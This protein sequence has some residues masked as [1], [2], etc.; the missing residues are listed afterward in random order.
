MNT[1]ATNDRIDW[2][3]TPVDPDL[4]RQLS[5]PNDRQGFIQ[6]AGHLAILLLLGVITYFV[7]WHFAWYWVIPCLLAY[8]SAYNMLGAGVHE[9]IHERVFKTPWLNRFF[10]VI[11][12][13]FSWVNY[14]LYLLSHNEHHKFTLHQPDDLEVALPTK[15]RIP[16]FFLGLF[17]SPQ[18]AFSFLRTATEL[19]IGV[20]RGPWIKHLLDNAEPRTR[21]W[22]YG[23]SRYHLLGHGL[24]VGLSLYHGQW[25]IPLLTTF[26]PTYATFVPMLTGLPQHAGLV[27]NVNDFRLC[28]RTIYLNPLFT[29]LYWRM[30]YHIDHHMYPVVPCYNLPKLH[31]AIKHELPRTPKGL[32]ETW[33]QI[34]YILERQKREPD[35]QY[36][37]PLP[38]DP[39][40][41]SP[42]PTPRNKGS[43]RETVTTKVWEC[44]LCGFIYDEREG[45]PEEGFAPGTAWGDIPDE[46]VC[47]VCGVAKSQFKMIEITREAAVTRTPQPIDAH[48]DPIV[49]VG[50]GIAGYGLVREFRKH[51]PDQPVVIITQDGGE[52]YYKPMLSNAMTVGKQANDLV[53]AEHGQMAEQ[54]NAR[55]MTHTKVVWID[56]KTKTIKTTNEDI[57]YHKLVLAVG[58]DQIE[59]PIEGDAADRILTVNDLDGFRAFT[60]VLAPGA[61]VLLIGAGLIGC[62]FANDLVL[63]GHAVT[64]VDIADHPLNRLL[65]P[66]LGDALRDEL[67][68]VGTSWMLGCSV[69]RIEAV[70]GTSDVVRCVLSNGRSLEADIV[71]SAVGLRP[72]TTLAAQAGLEFERGIL[73]NA[74]L[75]TSDPNIYAVGD[76]IEFDGQLMPYVMPIMHEGKA[77]ARTLAGQPTTVDF[78]VMPVTVKTTTCPAVVAPPRPEADGRWH[79]E[80]DRA[81]VYRDPSGTMQGFALLGGATEQ[82][83]RYV[84]MMGSA[85]VFEKATATVLPSGHPAS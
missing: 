76:C 68:A 37:A 80:R 66:E 10:L 63:S 72:R 45:L 46:W 78:P 32:W 42:D 70:T 38:T 52:S 29:F 60:Q 79:V 28:C 69:Q 23:F 59:L 36:R 64:V 4:M 1:N 57:R 81:A 20:K 18:V 6:A 51:S 44:T 84:E 47:P 13:F 19:A 50:S 31:E 71:L 39:P 16:W 62:E 73:V 34:C 77:L 40:S 24:I 54:L 83:A 56:A 11:F 74:M 3:R 21:R 12:G 48:A 26:A 2:Y 49:I 55:V 61:R 65:P 15:I 67:A 14:R 35:Y 25:I 75:Q 8:G 53:L 9:L 43:K 82:T 17:C 7:W 27:D 41:I 5:E 85:A 30:N 58:A 33:V 22:V